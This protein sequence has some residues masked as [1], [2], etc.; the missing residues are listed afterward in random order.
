M[1]SSSLSLLLLLLFLISNSFETDLKL[2][3]FCGMPSRLIALALV[4]VQTCIK[5]FFDG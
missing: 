3:E 5:F 1:F 2:C 4:V